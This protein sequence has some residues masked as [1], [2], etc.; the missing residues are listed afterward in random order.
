M[1]EKRATFSRRAKPA[2]REGW[3]A[4][5]PENVAAHIEASAPVRAVETVADVATM[6]LPGNLHNIEQ[7]AAADELA[8]KAKAQSLR[9]Y[10]LASWGHAI[11]E[12]FFTSGLLANAGRAAYKLVIGVALAELFYFAAVKPFLEG[13]G[14]L[15]GD[16]MLLAIG[17]MILAG[18]FGVFFARYGVSAYREIDDDFKAAARDKDAKRAQERRSFGGLL[19]RALRAVDGLARRVLP[20]GWAFAAAEKL[21]PDA[22]VMAL[23]QAF[24]GHFLK[25][26]RSWGERIKAVS[27]IADDFGIQSLKLDHVPDELVTSL[28][29]SGLLPN[30]QPVGYLQAARV[31]ERHLG[32]AARAGLAMGL[33][34]AAGFLL[35]WHPALLNWASWTSTG[36]WL[37]H[38]LVFDPLMPLAAGAAVGLATF[39][40]QLGDAFRGARFEF[41]TGTVQ[42]KRD[43]D[44]DRDNHVDADEAYTEQVLSYKADKSERCF[45]GV[46]T[47]ILNRRGHHDA[48]LRGTRMGFTDAAMCQHLLVT[49][50]TGQGKSWSIVEPLLMWAMGVSVKLQ[51]KGLRQL[52]ARL[53]TANCV[54]ALARPEMLRQMHY[55]DPLWMLASMSCF[56]VDPKGVFPGIVERLAQLM[57]QSQ[58]VRRLGPKKGEYIVDLLA[59]LTPQ[60]A[61]D[62]LQ[63]AIERGATKTSD[64]MWGE[65]AK[66]IE[67]AALALAQVWQHTDNGHAYAN[68][69]RVMP[70]SYLFIND[71][72]FDPQDEMIPRCLEDIWAAEAAGNVHVRALINDQ[73]MR[74]MR[75]LL[76]KDWLGAPAENE[77]KMGIRINVQ[78][79]LSPIVANPDL[80]HTFGAGWADNVM[81]FDEFWTAGLFTVSNINEEI[82]GEPAIVINTL[83]KTRYLVEADVREARFQQAG[84]EA[85]K[86]LREIHM[87]LFQTELADHSLQATQTYLALQAQA[88]PILRRVA[89]DLLAQGAWAFGAQGVGTYQ[90]PSFGP[91]LAQSQFNRARRFIRDDVERLNAI[92]TQSGGTPVS[93]QELETLKL[94]DVFRESQTTAGVAAA[95]GNLNAVALTNNLGFFKGTS[96]AMT[97]LLRSNQLGLEAVIEGVREEE[98]LLATY[99]QNLGAPASPRE[100][101]PA[102]PKAIT[103]ARMMFMVDEYTSLATPRVDTEAAKK[104][105]SKALSLVFIFQTE[106]TLEAALGSAEKKRALMEN[107]RTR[108]VLPDE[109]PQ[110]LQTI[111]ELTDKTLVREAPRSH[112]GEVELPYEVAL[113]TNGLS[114]PSVPLCQTPAALDQFCEAVPCSEIP[115]KRRRQ[116]AATAPLGALAD[117]AGPL[118]MNE[119]RSW[120]NEPDYTTNRPMMTG[121]DEDENRM[122]SWRQSRK[123][124]AESRESERLNSPRRQEEAFNRADWADNNRAYFYTLL[125]RRAR[126]D[127]ITLN[128]KHDRIIADT[129]ALLEQNRQMV[130]A[131]QAETAR[132]QQKAA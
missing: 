53:R 120:V 16:S 18:G 5:M 60:K 59:G 55:R 62:L 7:A 39:R 49:G 34:T 77:T 75:V 99:I 91:G 125:G 8:N 23:H 10:K 122:I 72:I 82:Y 33:A 104:A 87:H 117:L 88:W 101:L 92:L 45:I 69:N 58:N 73:F 51:S 81:T 76:G 89:R 70:Y 20:T 102:V 103:R 56:L 50:A 71:L 106:A 124:Q 17:Q 52:V 127:L 80:A 19:G 61:L 27:K 13:F 26:D 32:A 6:L 107:F 31:T 68:A 21:L 12:D 15:G 4:L 74:E 84:E 67:R 119:G 126:R 94:P 100:G 64:K 97:D 22:R 40:G 110:T 90:T 14:L 123:D 41:D 63:E 47:G 35:F 128:T 114:D 42:Q 46:S 113:H 79:Q 85:E 78:Q 96:R 65:L 44:L 93:A 116:V 24:A 37:A 98:E 25:R 57:G 129:Q 115:A 105:R 109:A 130:L 118:G 29:Y 86:A 111:R 3:R 54:K 43:A 48:P 9:G 108:I 112:L 36:S 30:K 1:F 132:Q 83:I 38:A 121:S 2:D 28:V 66:N 131:L 95:G 11:V